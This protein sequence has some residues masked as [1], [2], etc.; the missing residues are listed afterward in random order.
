MK[1]LHNEYKPC[2][3]TSIQK[4]RARKRLACRSV[5]TRFPHIYT[6][7]HL[8]KKQF[9][10]QILFGHVGPSE[11]RLRLRSTPWRGNECRCKRGRSP[12][13]PLK[14]VEF[15]SGPGFSESSGIRRG[16]SRSGGMETTTRKHFELFTVLCSRRLR[17]QAWEEWHYAGWLM[18]FFF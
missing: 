4:I 8:N 2:P 9:T 3:R 1:I 18:H 10:L 17:D 14:T 12:L 7:S 15:K 5:S 16:F 11:L 6:Q 13:N